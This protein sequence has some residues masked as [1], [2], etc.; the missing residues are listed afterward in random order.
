M[1]ACLYLFPVSK[2]QAI[3]DVE[4]LGFVYHWNL[5]LNSITVIGGLATLSFSHT[6]A[7]GW[8]RCFLVAEEMIN[9]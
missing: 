5:Q 1:F 7:T 6:P 2:I 3:I 8:Y 9:F 4:L